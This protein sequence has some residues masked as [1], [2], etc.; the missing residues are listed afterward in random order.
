MEY[1]TNARS[2]SIQREIIIFALL[3]PSVLHTHYLQSYKN[4]FE[5]CHNHTF[6][7]T[8]E[9]RMSKNNLIMAVNN[10]TDDIIKALARK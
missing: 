3:S 10:D 9:E 1:I 4:Y 2:S 6:I 5:I 8:T 7:T